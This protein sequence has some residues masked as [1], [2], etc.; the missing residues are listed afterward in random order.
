ME[1]SIEGQVEHTEV[2][3][4]RRR[5]L[6]CRVADGSGAILLRFFHFNKYQSE[7]LSPGVSVRCFGEA[8]RGPQTMEMV[9]PE[10]R[11]LLEDQSS[12]EQIVEV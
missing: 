11:L 8:R 5:M 6:L 9:H 12:D 7:S 3:F 4:R 1:I 2:V 10:Y